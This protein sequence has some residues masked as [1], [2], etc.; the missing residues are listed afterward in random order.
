MEKQKTF[1]YALRSTWQGVSNMYNKAA[2]KFDS[3]MATGFVLLN[4]EQNGTPSTSL[5]PKMGM[6]NT[7]LSRILNTLEKRSL[8]E[9]K[10]NP[11]DGRSRLIHLTKLGLEKREIS[12]KIVLEFNK[13]VSD[14]LKKEEINIFFKVIN[15]INRQSQKINQ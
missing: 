5:G 1:D 14:Q 2:G 9:R 7:S 11:N 3:T 4:I 13:S 10:L 6:E 12:K 15:C 8:I